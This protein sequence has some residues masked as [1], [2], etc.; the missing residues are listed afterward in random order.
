MGQR[1]GRSAAQHGC[2]LVAATHCHIAAGASYWLTH[3]QGI[4]IGQCHGGIRR[5]SPA[6]TLCG[7]DGQWCIGTGDSHNVFAH[8]LQRQA[9]SH[10]FE[11][12]QV[13]G[14]AHQAVGGFERCL[15]HGTGGGYAL[16][17]LTVATQILKDSEQACSLDIYPPLS[18]FAASPQG[19]GAIAA[20]RLLLG[21]SLLDARQFGEQNEHHHAD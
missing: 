12:G 1:V 16:P 3:G 21:T 6:L 10:S 20:R 17:G 18:R 4:A 13:A 11:C 14:I 19:D 15:I 5:C 7:G 8:A 9:A 2:N